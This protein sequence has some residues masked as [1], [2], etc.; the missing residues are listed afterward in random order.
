MVGF[1]KSFFN[2]NLKGGGTLHPTLYVS[3]V[4]AMTE[5]FAII[6][7]NI[8]HLFPVPG[9]FIIIIFYACLALCLAPR[10]RTSRGNQLTAVSSATAVLIWL[11]LHSFK[12]NIKSSK[13][14]SSIYHRLTIKKAKYLDSWTSVRLVYFI[15]LLE[16]FPFYKLYYKC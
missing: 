8:W 10:A 14:S 2:R 4:F 15:Q 13:N 5:I 16:E 11:N 7:L 6:I 1:T 9:L 12:K 3:F